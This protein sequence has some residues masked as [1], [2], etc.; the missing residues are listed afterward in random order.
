MRGALIALVAACGSLT[1]AAG[2]ARAA[3]APDSLPATRVQDLHYGDV[4]FHFYQDDNFEALTRLL[5]YEQ[6]GRM[7]HHLAAAE[8]LAGG[9][10]LSLGMHNEAG[11]RFARLLTDGT[12]PGVRNRAWFYLGKV[13]YAR[14]YDDKAEQALRSVTGLLPAELEAEKTHL[15]ANVLMHGG[16]YDEAVQ[17]L[18]S[19]Q[20]R[21]DW[22]AYARFNLGVALVRKGQLPDA[23]R[24]LTSVGEMAAA[25]PEM[26]AL[27]DKA[28]LALGFAYL[29]A[30]QPANAK[31]VLERVRL[32]GPLSNKALLGAGWADAALG[33]FESALAPWLELRDRNLLDAAVQESWLAVP[34][35]YGKLGANAQA[36]EYYETAMREFDKEGA[37]LGKTIEHLRSTR[38]L[39]DLLAGETEDRRGWFWQLKELPDAPQSRYLYAVLAGH[40][41]Q[42]G[43]KNYRDLAF[44]KERLAAWSGSMDA[45]HDMV[46]ARQ[47]AYAGRVPRADALL[48]TDAPERI[49]RERGELESRLDTIER[50]HDA[51]ALGTALERDQW[52]RIRRLEQALANGDA[53][54]KD[55]LRLVKGVLS[56]RL[57]E[58][59]RARVYQQR[60]EIRDLDAALREA[61]R[62]WV[63]VEKAR[64][65]VP[66][67][68]GEFE[69]RIEA[70]ASRLAAL[71]ARLETARDRQND[72]LEAMAVHELES[73][74]ERLAA[75]RVQ[76]R[77]ALA[78]I[79]DRAANAPAAGTAPDGVAPESDAPAPV[80]ASP[81]PG[82]ESSR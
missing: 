18:D 47:K 1:A 69:V 66:T 57:D 33:D 77:F 5:A 54:M 81:P 9:L 25:T 55:R 46:D 7:P 3:A 8:L 6:W 56:W 58:A 73:Q 26:L 16:R 27:K 21:A 75:Y 35:A 50:T 67:N 62:R 13:W 4:L 30:G 15:L 23:D 32:N 52:A 24:Y 68:T 42:E 17:L 38:L 40:D 28:N 48:A 39:D 51:A 76:A 64:K 82:G 61:Q 41:F 34:Y 53:G 10:Y 79:Y 49:E 37:S 44:M 78:T 71:Q 65:N 14:G 63:R 60:R 12:P 22:V 74:Q 59:M 2:G 80:P 11:E 43:L 19:F 45:F 20:G 36:A 72:H 70:L 31:V 29:Q